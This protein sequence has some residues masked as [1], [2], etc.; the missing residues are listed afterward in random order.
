MHKSF[1][2]KRSSLLAVFALL[3]ALL[4]TAC[5]SSTATTAPAVATTSAAVSASGLPVFPSFKEIVLDKETLTALLKS[6]PGLPGTSQLTVFVSDE[7]DQTKLTAEIETTLTKAGYKVPDAIKAAGAGLPG[8]GLYAKA[9]AADIFFILGST[10]DFSVESLK[11]GGLSDA[12]IQSFTGQI[13]SKKSVMN[14]ISGPGLV[15]AS[16]AANFPPTAG[17]TP[18]ASTDSGFSFGLNYPSGFESLFFSE[19]SIKDAFAKTYPGSPKPIVFFYGT[20]ETDL[21][22]VATLMDE[23]LTNANGYQ[24]ALASQPKPMKQGNYYTGF[25]SKAGAPDAFFTAYSVSD[26]L[27]NDFTSMKN[28]GLTAADFQKMTDVLKTKKSV[29]V[30]AGAPNLVKTLMP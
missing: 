18:G 28:N 2:L 21:A 9:G 16:L 22:K 19:G 27:T 14:I 23:S 13:K 24:P 7:A 15:Q 6:L 11:A 12:T 4:L 3:F 1:R 10:S 20:D 17:G 25:Y 30:V 26:F 29:V 5:G 8:I